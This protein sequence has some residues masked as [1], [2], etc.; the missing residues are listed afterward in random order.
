MLT[1]TSRSGYTGQPPAYSVSGFSG[2]L[3]ISIQSMPEEQ[4]GAIYGSG[5]GTLTIAITRR[6]RPRAPFPD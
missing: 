3:P 5:D 1:M 2:A 4:M 6:K